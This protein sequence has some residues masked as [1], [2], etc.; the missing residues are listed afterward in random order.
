[1]NGV[2]EIPRVIG[3]N[4]DDEL[5][6][7]IVASGELQCVDCFRNPLR[8]LQNFARKFSRQMI[9]P[10]NRKHVHAWRRCEPEHF[11]DFALG[12]HMARLPVVETH[13]DFVADCCGGLRPPII[14]N[15]RH[16]AYVNIVHET[17]IIRHHVIKIP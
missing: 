14:L 8:L 9:L 17:R 16:G 3:V 6:A 1:M 4:S 15:R 2:V 12:I 13:H 7:Q 11:D 5:V 10:N